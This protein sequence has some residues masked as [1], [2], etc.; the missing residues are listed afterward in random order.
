MP[1]SNPPHDTLHL[2]ELYVTR[3]LTDELSKKFVYHDIEYAHR[4]IK[5]LKEI[6][7][8][9]SVSLDDRETLLI[10]GWMNVVGYT[11]ADKMGK[12]ESPSDLFAKCTE[13]SIGL[14]K[15]FLKEI[16]YSAKKR[17]KITELLQESRPGAHERS[18]LG[19]IL[20]DAITI[21]W[22]KP[23]A[24]KKLKKLYEEFLLTDAISYGR[25]AWNEV[26]LEY[27]GS[28]VYYTNFG[29]EF[30]DPIKRKLIEKIEK[31]KKELEKTEKIII[32]KELDISDEELKK[33]KK[34]LSSVK[35]RDDRGIQTL[36]RTT[37]RNH[38]TLNQ[39]VDRK[40]SI[41]ISINAILLSLILSRTLGRVDTFCVHNSPILILLIGCIIS[42]LLATAAITPSKTHGVFTE[43]EI[44][45]KK[46][47]LLYF[48]NFHDMNFRDYQ[49][50][51]LQMLNDSNYLYSSMVQDLYFLGQT[52]NK[53]SKLIRASLGIFMIGLTI[54]V[55][56]F[57]IVAGMEDFHFGTAYHE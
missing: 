16:K 7:E 52:L 53:K 42:I 36:F 45:N 55:I 28:H 33:L 41:M 19:S 39:M 18:E 14:S 23:K 2:V 4:L 8:F 17:E 3:A 5:G 15:S 13:C 38:Y 22:G 30:L 34:S 35:G 57:L 43:D 44:R 40:A 48:G 47:N 12:I 51:M 50:G 20:S 9:E 29:K 10:A 27:L 37:S 46:G 24:K 54:A 11:H 21:D 32:Q 25:G 6:S 56:A 26:V 31:E 49:W 1:I